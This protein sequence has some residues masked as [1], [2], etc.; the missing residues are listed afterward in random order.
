MPIDENTTSPDELPRSAAWLIAASAVIV[1]VLFVFVDPIA[2]DS[3]YHEFV[4]AR[5]LFAIPN[6]WN[7][8]S[9][10][11]FLFVGMYGFLIVRRYP[12]LVRES[13]LHRAWQVF[14]IGVFLTSFGSGYYHLAPANATL[15]W[16]RLPMTIA[17]SGLF[18]LVI[19]EYLSVRAARHLLIPL[20]LAGAASVVYWDVTEA[21][22]AGDLRPY[23]V[24]QFLP[25]ILTCAILV[26]YRRASDLTRYLWLMIAMYTIAKLLE[27]F[28]AG[29]YGILG[30]VSGH[31]LKHVAAS[32][33]PLA[34]LFALHA[35][36]RV[37]HE[38]H[39][40]EETGL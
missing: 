15:V 36:A 34:L 11:P 40:D 19:G 32:L 28:D 25:M 35:R 33:G 24:V 14:F 12:L 22:G 27:F 7:V 18:T 38:D 39:A 3:A 26:M 20:L 17:F 5:R 2:Q 23:A 9:N 1:I 29:I 8:A 31:S 13:G 21:R 4:D 37:T 16:D 10:L 6:F 30:F